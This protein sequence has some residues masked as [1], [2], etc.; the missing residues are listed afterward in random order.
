MA[1]IRTIKPELAAHEELFDLEKETTLP[2]RFAWC[3][4]FT[5]CDREGRFV[6]RPRTLKAQVLPHDNLDFSRVLDAWLSRGF[7][8]KYRVEGTWYGW[9]P[10]FTKH[11]VINNR[12]SASDLPSIQEAEEVSE[13]VDA[14][15]TRKR[16]VTNGNAGEPHATLTHGARVKRMHKG[17]EGRKELQ[18][19][20]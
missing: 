2:I 9:I 6:W 20:E 8:R 11:Q 7:V 19:E 12:E 15:S 3:M 10:T 4:L 13:S 5:V 17:K 18:S 14:T 1:R 16:R